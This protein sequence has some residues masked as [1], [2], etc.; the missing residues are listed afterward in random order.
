MHGYDACV[1]PYM[2]MMNV[3]T[4]MHAER[5]WVWPHAPGSRTRQALSI[6][7]VKNDIPYHISIKL[8]QRTNFS[9]LAPWGN[10]G[11]DFL[12]FALGN[13]KNNH[14]SSWG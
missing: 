11:V 14:S 8:K 3:K 12:S 1:K 7:R 9:P 2:D 4:I 13:K 6:Y 5:D 10:L